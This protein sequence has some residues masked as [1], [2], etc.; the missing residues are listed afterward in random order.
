M[1]LHLVQIFF[2]DARTFITCLL[3]YTFSCHYLDLWAAG[4]FEPVDDTPA[5][6]IIWGEF[7]KHLVTWKNLDKILP[8]PP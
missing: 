6:Q 8:H 7:N 1:S 3:Y 2:T 5:S 4:L